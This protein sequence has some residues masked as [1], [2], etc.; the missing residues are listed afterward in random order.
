MTCENTKSLIS[1]NIKPEN[2]RRRVA[3][4]GAGGFLGSKLVPALVKSGFSV[5]A[6][7]SRNR[8]TLSAL[9]NT[10]LNNLDVE[11]VS[12][13]NRR[14]IRDCLHGSEILLNCGFPQF[15]DGFARARG[16][17]FTNW[18]FEAA[19]KCDMEL[20]V[21]VSSQSVYDRHRTE[22]AIE[23]KAP[24]PEGDYAVAKYA[25]ELFLGG[26]CSN[27]PHTNL[28]LATLIGPG[29]DMRIPNKIMRARLI[30][31]ATFFEEGNRFGF[32]DV[33]D[34]VDGLVELCARWKNGN[35]SPVYNLSAS[36]SYSITEIAQIA[37]DIAEKVF[38]EHT[39][40]LLIE[41]RFSRGP[42][43]ETAVDS[44]LFEKQF[45]W[46]AKRTFRDSINAIATDYNSKDSSI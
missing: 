17:E 41:K 13:G 44:S 39:R 6:I 36:G 18:L 9:C 33:L 4:T 5:V 12:I 46:R 11:I 15:G 35:L 30:G 32:M 26:I 24:C 10:D 28:R 45:E 23:T 1:K 38:K 25:T 43:I 22:P 40:N 7:T 34:A 42:A 20:V 21:N 19:A 2:M 31:G 29:S 8:Q 16:L 14:E 3:L 27:V 37:N